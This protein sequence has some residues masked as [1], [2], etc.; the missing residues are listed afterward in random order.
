MARV[1]G[2]V[3]FRVAIP[4]LSDHVHEV[5]VRRRGRALAV[6]LDSRN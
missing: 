1:A 6:E 2:G 4:Q 5:T 3:R